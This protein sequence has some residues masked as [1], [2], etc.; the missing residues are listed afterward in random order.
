MNIL[1][2]LP[3]LHLQMKYTAQIINKLVCPIPLTFNI[4][5]AIT[6]SDYKV[7]YVDDSAQQIEYRKKYDLVGITVYTRNAMRA[8]QIADEFRKRNVKV[9]LG[10]W[11]VSA[12][13]EEAKARLGLIPRPAPSI[14]PDIPLITLRR[15]SFSLDC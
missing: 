12:L 9:V 15:S 6:P 7:E 8:Y 14:L 10:G 2:I 1:F 4:L 13:P 11:H 5:T 3:G